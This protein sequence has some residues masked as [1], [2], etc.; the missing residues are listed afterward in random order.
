MRVIG[1]P[2]RQLMLALLRITAGQLVAQMA[3]RTPAISGKHPVDAKP[4]QRPDR[5]RPALQEAIAEL[6]ARDAE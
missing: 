4:V 6:I 5:V 2:V 3:D 1:I